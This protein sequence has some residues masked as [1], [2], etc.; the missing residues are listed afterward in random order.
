MKNI[1]LI[2]LLGNQYIEKNK[3]NCELGNIQ[4]EENWSKNEFNIEKIG[5]TAYKLYQMCKDIK[6]GIDFDKI[7][8]FKK[9]YEKYH[10]R[11]IE[12]IFHIENIGTT[13]EIIFRFRRNSLNNY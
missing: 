6:S 1:K 2:N 7:K 11:I 8:Y 3:V 12:N 4:Y 5:E 13:N 9:E 10:D